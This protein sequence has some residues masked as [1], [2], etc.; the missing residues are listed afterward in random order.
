MRRKP[1]RK[2]LRLAAHPCRERVG[3]QRGGKP[4]LCLEPWRIVT[5]NARETVRYGTMTCMRGHEVTGKYA[6]LLNPVRRAK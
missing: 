5:L 2:A 6:T 4:S 3:T 1:T